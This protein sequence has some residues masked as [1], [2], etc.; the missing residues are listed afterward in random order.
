MNGYKDILKKM[1]KVL[2]V[3][4]KQRAFLRSINLVYDAASEE[5]VEHFYPTAKAVILIDA[6]M[7]A[8][9]S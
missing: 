4:N 5:C 2:M 9:K 7:G 3:V 1:T 6:I 8:N